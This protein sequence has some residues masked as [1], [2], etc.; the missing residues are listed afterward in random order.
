[1]Q[2]NPDVS[3]CAILVFI[4]FN[5]LQRHVGSS[6]LAAAVKNNSAAF[7]EFLALSRDPATV[8][9]LQDALQNG[10]TPEAIALVS[11][12]ERIVSVT[13]AFVPFSGAAR[14]AQLGNIIAMVRLVG[15]PTVFPTVSPDPIGDVA[16]MRAAFPTRNNTSF[17]AIDGGFLGSVQ[18]GVEFPVFHYQLVS[19]LAQVSPEALLKRT[20]LVFKENSYAAASSIKS[21]GFGVP[22]S[23]LEY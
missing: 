5:Q 4:L 16:A 23:A 15:L 13:A 6:K 1:L 19:S 21:P 8:P 22:A 20:S 7:A 17:P 18:K 3:A 11:K 10:S 12:L 14:K 9:A 2:F